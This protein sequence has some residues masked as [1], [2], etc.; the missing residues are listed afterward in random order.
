MPEG[1]AVVFDPIFFVFVRI[2]NSFVTPNDIT[3][4]YLVS[5]GFLAP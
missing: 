4:S 1:L 3:S 5:I 2:I